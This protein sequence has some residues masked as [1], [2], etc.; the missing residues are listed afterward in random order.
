M[1]TE[2]VERLLGQ[3]FNVR[4]VNVRELEHRIVMIL[5]Y[6]PQ[7]SDRLLSIALGLAGE[8]KCWLTVSEVRTI[9]DEGPN[10]HPPYQQ[11]VYRGRLFHPFSIQAIPPEAFASIA[12]F[13][14]VCRSLYQ[15]AVWG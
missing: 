9:G 2:E 14:R 6:S 10:P 12:M 11:F 7:D 8:S 13:E 4:V 1:N 15:H 3:R 5:D